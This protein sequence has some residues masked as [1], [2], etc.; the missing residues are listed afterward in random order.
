MD[1]T[2]LAELQG[3]ARL[4]YNELARRVHMSAPAV[5]ERVRRLEETGVITGYHARVNPALAGRGVAAL[6]RMTCYG[7]RCVLRDEQALAWPEILEVHRVTGDT[8]CLL[9]VAASSMIAFEELIDKLAPYGHPS[10]MMV[11]SSPVPWRPLSPV[12]D[13]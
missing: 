11:L 7:P 4:S 13:G 8:C 2:L 12:Q 9:R 3:D 6:I 1:W 10:S 5:A